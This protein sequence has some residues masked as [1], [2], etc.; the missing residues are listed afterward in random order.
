MQRLRGLSFLLREQE[1]EQG[2]T[3]GLLEL[4]RAGTCPPGDRRS[5]LIATLCNV[6]SEEPLQTSQA[7]LSARDRFFPSGDHGVESE[8]EKGAA[9]AP[10]TSASWGSQPD[11]AADAPPVEDVLE[12]DMREDEYGTSDHLISEDEEEHNVFIALSWTA[13]PGAPTSSW[14]DDEESTPASPSP[15]SDMLVCKHTAVWLGILWPVIVVETTRSHYEG[16]KLPLARSAMKQLL[17][18]FSELLAD[19]ACSWRG[20]PLSSRSPI[21]GAF[22]LDCKSMESSDLFRMPPVEPLVAGH[23]QPQPTVLSRSLSLPSK[24][25]ALSARALNVLSLLS[26]YQAELHKDFG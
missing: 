14:D 19:I 12:L 20:R 5:R 23:L 11:L 10:A 8:E 1:L 25:V 6:H 7:S 4:P 22:S 18:I 2:S 24:A 3:Q 26:A 9:A 15:S 13:Q 21:S 17:P 16:K